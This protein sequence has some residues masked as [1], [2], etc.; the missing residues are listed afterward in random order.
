MK[1]KVHRTTHDSKSDYLL[2]D[3]RETALKWIA[4]QTDFSVEDIED[5]INTTGSFDTLEYV[6]KIE[7]S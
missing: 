2:A 5:E 4:E 3:T 6:Y 1:F 7:A